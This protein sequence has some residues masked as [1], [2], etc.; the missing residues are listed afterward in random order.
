MDSLNYWYKKT[1][2]KVTIEYLVW[3]S[4]NDN[5]DHIKSLVE[6]CKVP[7]KVNIIEF[8]D[9]GYLKFKRAETS[10]IQ[11]YI[12]ILKINNIPV[13]IRTSRGRYKCCMRTISK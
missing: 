13:S 7:S 8:N 2:S 6:F 11:K 4:I 12:E 1:K 5:M 9:I 10:W 3:E